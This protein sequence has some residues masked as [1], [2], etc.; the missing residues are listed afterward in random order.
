M[1]DRKSTPEVHLTEKI[2]YLTPEKFSSSNGIPLYY[3]ENPS[4]EAARIELLF[5]AGSIYKSPVIAS[6]CIAMLLAGNESLSMAE[7]N[8]KIDDFGGYFGSNLSNDFAVLS[9]Y[10][11]NEVMVDLSK[12]IE[13]CITHPSFPQSEIDHF[14]KEKKEKLKVNLEKVNF[15]SQRSFQEN[16][17]HGTPYSRSTNE[18]D[19]DKVTREEIM[20]FHKKYFINGLRRITVVGNLPKDKLKEILSIFNTYKNESKS[21]EL[22]SSSAKKGNIHIPKEDAVQIGVRIGKM[23]CDRKDP[24]YH[25]MTIVNTIFGDYFGSRL[26]SNIR[27]DKGYTYGIGSF[28]AENKVGG[29]FG[30]GTE[31]AKDV[32]ED[33]IFQIQ[34][35]LNRMRTEPVPEEELELV[36]NY[37]LGQILKSADGPFAMMELFSAVEMYDL[38]YSFYDQALQVILSITPDQILE[39]AQRQLNWDEMLVITAG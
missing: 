7:I 16:L 5:N 28:L 22:K 11:L 18:T 2:K 38:D 32:I 4:S 30:I 36:K 27:E 12:F 35:E 8:D 6:A 20:A 33:T 24:D 13:N 19:Y 34:H 14:K 9:I 21:I 23:I 10:G 31:V 29:Y 25:K 17:F 1:I 39:T 37:L 26:M 15:L 3:F